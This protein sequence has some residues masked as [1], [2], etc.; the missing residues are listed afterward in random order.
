MGNDCALLLSFLL[1]SDENRDLFCNLVAN[2]IVYAYR[3]LVIF[4]AAEM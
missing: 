4:V 1:F 3:L 2:V